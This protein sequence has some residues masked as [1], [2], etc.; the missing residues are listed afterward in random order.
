MPSIQRHH[1]GADNANP[2][3][4][5]IQKYFRNISPVPKEEK[6][7]INLRHIKHMKDLER[8]DDVKKKKMEGVYNTV[9]AYTKKV[10]DQ[11]RT[12]HNL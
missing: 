4:E 2:L 5:G 3:E 1:L 11:Q 10:R 7:M 6:M 9:N 8:N 12:K